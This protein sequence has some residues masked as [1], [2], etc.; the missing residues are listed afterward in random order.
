MKYIVIPLLLLATAAAAQRSGKDYAVF[1]YVTD[2]QPGWAKLPE[3]AGEAAE[4]KAELENTYGFNCE[5]APNPSK[6]KILATLKAYNESLGENDQ[7]LLFFSMHGHY[8][9]GAERGFLVAADGALNDEYGETWL[10]YDDLSGYLSRCK[11]RHIL[12]ALDACHSGAFGIRNKARPDKAAFNQADD[13]NQ[14]IAKTMQFNGRQYC[15]SGNKDAKTPAKS[16]FASRFLEALRKG[17]HE[18]LLR[19]DD[20]EYYLGKIENPAPESGTFRGHVPGGDFVFVKKDGCLITPPM[21]ASINEDS[22][23]EQVW[24][25]AMKR[26]DV[27]IYLDEYP[28]G[29]YKERALLIQKELNSSSLSTNLSCKELIVHNIASRQVSTVKASD[30]LKDGHYLSDFHYKVEV[31]KTLPLGNG[32]WI[33]AEFNIQDTGKMFQIRISDPNTG[34]KCSSNVKI[35]E[36]ISLEMVYVKGGKFKKMKP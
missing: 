35:I 27:Q 8:D 15:S 12:L 24:K 21:R 28:N 31:D 23:E 3:T 9:P 26:N 2:F 30:V 36:S 33:P 5:T 29:K 16:R 14:R 18:G 25:I 11:A 34:N 10:S 17:G 7:L 6:A 4:L 32:P 22:P 13:C 1:F 20:L 19:F